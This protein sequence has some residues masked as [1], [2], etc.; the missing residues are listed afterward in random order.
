MSIQCFSLNNLKQ[1]EK[2]DIKVGL[3]ALRGLF[4]PHY[5]EIDSMIT[6]DHPQ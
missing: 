4:Q 2:G 5:S 6:L 1:L 3:D